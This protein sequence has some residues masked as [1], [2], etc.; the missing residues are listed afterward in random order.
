MFERESQKGKLEKSLEERNLVGEGVPRL[1]ESSL[2]FAGLRASPHGRQ[3]RDDGS[4]LL[5]EGHHKGVKYL[6]GAETAGQGGT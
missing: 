4:P 3:Q 1:S 2:L 5:T 6:A